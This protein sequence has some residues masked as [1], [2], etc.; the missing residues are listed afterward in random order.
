MR[1]LLFKEEERESGRLRDFGTQGLREKFQDDFL[2]RLTYNRK[3]E[4]VIKNS[5]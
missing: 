3:I 2:K 5:K 4:H 1:K